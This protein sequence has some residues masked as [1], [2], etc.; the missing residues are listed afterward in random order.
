MNHDL[1]HENRRTF[2]TTGQVTFIRNNESEIILNN[3]LSLHPLPVTSSSTALISAVKNAN[4]VQLELVIPKG[5]EPGKDHAV[6]YE[7]ISKGLVYD[8]RVFVNGTPYIAKTG[9]MN[10]RYTAGA[11]WVSGSYFFEAEDGNKFAGKF[12]LERT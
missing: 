5:F 9:S 11:L 1:K 12:E 10:F 3:Y 7:E 4:G 8:W 6:S 2:S